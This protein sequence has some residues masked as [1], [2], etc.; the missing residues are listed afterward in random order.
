MA[1][2]PLVALGA[3][4]VGTSIGLVGIGG[5]FLIPLLVAVQAI[6]IHEAIA[7]ALITFV[8]AGLFGTAAHAAQ[9]NINWRM[10]LLTSASSL[11]LGPVGAWVSV[12][13][14]ETVVKLIFAAFLLFV[15]VHT[16]WQEVSRHPAG[17]TERRPDQF[18]SIVLL[19]CGALVG[20]GS[21]LTGVGG[22]AI[23]VPLLVALGIPVRLAVG[24]S[25]VNQIA[26]AGSGAAGHL[27]FGQVDLQ[28]AA[29]VTVFEVAGVVLGA[30]IGRRL[31][32]NALR[33]VVAVLCVGVALWTA[34]GLL[35]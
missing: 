30:Q 6:S 22:P 2:S 25:Q 21:G 9:G 8:F 14:P 19:G 1:V 7:T 34:G 33:P 26:A 32:S 31:S 5:I 16:L 28:L 11:A 3:L 15:G 4:L 18:S 12:S 23:L 17:R 13:L 24:V 10:A 27:L 35:G 20:F 29:A